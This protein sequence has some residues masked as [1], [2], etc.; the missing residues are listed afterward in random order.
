MDPSTI[1]ENLLKEAQS[2]FE[3]ERQPAVV[4]HAEEFFRD[5]TGARYDKV[6]SPSQQVRNTRDRLCG[7]PQTT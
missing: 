2:K 5:I 1:A 7:R 3:M 6:F 4:R